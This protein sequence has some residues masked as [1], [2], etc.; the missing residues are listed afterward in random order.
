MKMAILVLKYIQITL[1]SFFFLAGIITALVL[2]GWLVYNKT[3]I[4][5]AI[6]LILLAFYLYARN[7]VKTNKVN[8]DEIHENDI[9]IYLVFFSILITIMGLF[10]IVYVIEYGKDAFLI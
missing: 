5:L 8:I 2:A 3:S 10:G 7:R 9:A 1:V 6:G 4:V